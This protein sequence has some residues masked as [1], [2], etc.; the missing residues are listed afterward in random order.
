MVTLLQME[1]GS[2]CCS[3]LL[4]RSRVGSCSPGAKAHFMPQF[5]LEDPG[6]ALL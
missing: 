1:L 3:Q 4:P 5:A 2:G 6:R